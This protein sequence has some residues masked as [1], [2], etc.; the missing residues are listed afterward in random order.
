NVPFQNWAM[1]APSLNGEFRFAEHLQKTDSG[2]DRLI[3]PLM[4]DCNAGCV[5]ALLNHFRDHFPYVILVAGAE[6]PVSPLIECIRQADWTYLLLQ[7]SSDNRQDF[8]LLVPEI[9]SLDK[10]D[11]TN[12]KPILCLEE[13]GRASGCDDLL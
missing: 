12:I 7:P 1:S 4:G 5:A 11:G 13:N 10:N 6:T 2:F 8:D 3:L 9:H